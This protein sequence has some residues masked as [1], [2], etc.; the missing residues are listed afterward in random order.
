MVEEGGDGYLERV[1]K[2]VPAE[3]V[4]FFLFVNNILHAADGPDHKGLMAS[5]PVHYVA[6]AVLIIGLILT[7]IYI[8]CVHEEGEEWKFNAVVSTI[9]FP[10]W[11]YAMGAVAWDT[12]H[13]GNF[14]SILLATF[15]VCS[16]LLKPRAKQR[17]QMNNAPGTGDAPGAGDKTGGATNH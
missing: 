2:Y 4:G 13:D 17:N 10:I 8:W 15:T 6:T 3:V 14:A 12:V 9:A 11:A 7:P 5:L 16:G 1:A